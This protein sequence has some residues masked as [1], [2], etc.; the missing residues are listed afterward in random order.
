MVERKTLSCLRVPMTSI[1]TRR[2]LARPS[3]VL[4]LG[5][6]LLLALAL[7]VDAVRLDALRHQVGLDRFGAAHRQPLVVGVG[8]DRVGVADGDHHLEVD[9]FRLVRDVVE[10]RLAL[11]LD[12]R[13]VEVEQHVGGE[14]HLL[15]HGLGLLRLRAWASPAPARAAWAP[16]GAAAWV[17]APARAAARA[18]ASGFGGSV[19][20][21]AASAS[22]TRSIHTLLIIESPAFFSLERNQESA[23]TLEGILP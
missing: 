5:D 4:L 14:G 21:P 2:F 18:W 9:A 12:H 16:A 20:Q 17:R 11:G 13:L 6:G 19:A 22:A 3:A 1:S 8:A 7:G 23:S 15:G 10:L